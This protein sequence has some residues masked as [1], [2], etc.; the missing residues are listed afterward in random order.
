MAPLGGA[1]VGGAIGLGSAIAQ[2]IRARKQRKEADKINPVRP[3]M[4]RT[5]ASKENQAL[6][7]QGANSTRLPGQGYA[8]NKIGAQTARATNAV[9]GTGGSTSEI[10]SGL[11]K[12]DQ[13][14]REAT[15]DLAMKG[16]ELNLQNKQLYGDV[17]N[18]VSEEEKELF[19][20]NKNQP[21]QTD[22]LR[23]QALIDSSARNTDNA[24]SGLQDTA[25]NVGNAIGYK[26][27]LKDEGDTIMPGDNSMA[28][29]LS[30][31]KRKR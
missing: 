16:A 1:L 10:I 23:K 3:L 20:Y 19:D 14:S 26:N 24:L 12:V 15:N 25:Q 28:T 18:R 4:E 30:G 21:Y 7:R 8:E 5:R 11:T 17:L 9:L 29:S 13:N 2:G 27:A 6:F 22:V 31:R